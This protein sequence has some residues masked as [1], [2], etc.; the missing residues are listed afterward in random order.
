VVHPIFSCASR[1]A[2]GGTGVDAEDADDVGAG[3]AA[4]TGASIGGMDTTTS[5][6]AGTSIGVGGFT[7]TSMGS[8][9]SASEMTTT[10]G[11]T[12]GAGWIERG[13]LQRLGE[14]SNILN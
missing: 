12:R 2:E 9:S 3:V 1:A 7:S 11:S 10:S 6:E 14:A 13:K 8:S 4:G 5:V